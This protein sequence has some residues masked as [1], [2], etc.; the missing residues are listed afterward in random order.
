MSLSFKL[1]SWEAEDR[2]TIATITKSDTEDEPF[3]WE[4]YSKVDRMVIS[5]G[6]SKTFAKAKSECQMVAATVEGAEGW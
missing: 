1:K 6:R 4:T 2:F 3:Y 5:A